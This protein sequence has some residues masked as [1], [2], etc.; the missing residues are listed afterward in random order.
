MLSKQLTL[1]K[2]FIS[3]K[4]FVLPNLHTL[5]LSISQYL[6]PY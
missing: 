4:L 3:I 5:Y 1:H 6:Y 2:K